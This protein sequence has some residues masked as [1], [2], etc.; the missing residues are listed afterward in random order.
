MYIYKNTVMGIQLQDSSF[1]SEVMVN[2]LK[3]A[4]GEKKKQHKKNKKK[5]KKNYQDED[6]KSAIN[7]N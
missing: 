3:K 7:K 1:L 4:R 6:K 5:Q 2:H